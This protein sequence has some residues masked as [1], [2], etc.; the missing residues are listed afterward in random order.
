MNW[1]ALTLSLLAASVLLVGGSNA[2]LLWVATWRIR[3]RRRGAP[4]WEEQARRE[5]ARAERLRDL[6]W[7]LARSL[8]RTARNDAARRLERRAEKGTIAVRSNDGGNGSTGSAA[9]GP[10]ARGVALVALLTRGRQELRQAERSDI[11]VGSDRDVAERVLRDVAELV[12]R[13]NRRGESQA[14][15]A[16]FTVGALASSTTD[17]HVRGGDRRR[18]AAEARA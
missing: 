14:A 10:T 4:D 2:W 15:D 7:R 12:N 9:R 18:A 16:W 1:W 8:E 3:Q 17:R 6:C 13:A 11:L 5:K